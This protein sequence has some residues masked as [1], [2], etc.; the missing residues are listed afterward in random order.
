MWH[1]MKELAGFR[2]H[3]IGYLAQ[4]VKAFDDGIEHNDQMLPCVKV[5]YIPLTTGFTT[6]FKNSYLVKQRK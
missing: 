6:D 2:K 3:G 1:I 4:A 5:L